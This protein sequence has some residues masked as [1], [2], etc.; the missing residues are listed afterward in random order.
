MVAV[1]P[2]STWSHCGSPNALDHRV[3]V[4]PSTAFDAGYAALSVDDAVAGRP[5]DSSAP[6]AAARFE[7]ATAAYPATTR[8]S[9]A[10]RASRGTRTGTAR[11]RGVGG[12]EE[13]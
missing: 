4:L 6:A 12:C 13:G 3:P 10:T 11:A 9:T 8:S 7:A 2:R 1:A 5:C